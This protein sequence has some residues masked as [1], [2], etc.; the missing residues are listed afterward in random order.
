MTTHFA[1]MIKHA[2][3]LEEHVA[4]SKQ[5]PALQNVTE[6]SPPKEAPQTKQVTT[7]MPPVSSATPSLPVNLAGVDLGKISS[8]LST[9][10]NVMKNSGEAV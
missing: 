4:Q 5:P 2:F 7:P 1:K 8:I 9:L 6:T 10:T 3:F